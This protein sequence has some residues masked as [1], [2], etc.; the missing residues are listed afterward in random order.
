MSA[1]SVDPDQNAASDL[2]LL[3]LQR[4]SVRLL[5]V[6]KVAS[7]YIQEHMFDFI[8]FISAIQ[9]NLP[10]NFCKTLTGKMYHMSNFTL[11]VQGKHMRSNIRKRTFGHVRPAKIQISLRIRAV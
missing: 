3:C 2:C 1:N 5:M 11:S 7:L 6:N 4:T 8:H 9:I 10:D